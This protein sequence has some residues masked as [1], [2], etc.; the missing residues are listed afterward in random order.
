MRE[1]VAGR[2]VIRPNGIVMDQL[3]KII[4]NDPPSTRSQAAKQLY[5][6]F[7]L[8]YTVSRWRTETGEETSA[9]NRGTC[10]ESCEFRFAEI[11]LT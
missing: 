10:L 6:R 3:K 5:A 7:H 11:Y 8:G 4:Q 2:Q 9:F 1:V